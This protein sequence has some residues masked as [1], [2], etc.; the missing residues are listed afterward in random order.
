M[1]YQALLATASD[2]APATAGLIGVGEFGLTL[3]AQSRRIDGLALK[4][5]CDQ[6]PDRVRRAAVAL[7]WSENRVAFANDRRAA[8]AAFERGDLVVTDDW[9]VAVELPIDVVVEAT[10]SAE[11]GA[12]TASAAIDNGRHLVLVTKETDAVIGPLLSARARAAGLVLSQVD[13]D[14]PSLTMGLVSWA[15]ALGLEIVCAGKASTYDFVIDLEA[16]CVTSDGITISV[17]DAERLWA[18]PPASPRELVAARAAACEAMARRA[19]PDFCEIC[20]IANG[21][22]LQPDI[23]EL[24]AAIART[25]ELPDLFRPEASGGV[26]G[27][28]GRLDVFNCFRR[29]DEISFA[30]G[31]FAVVGLPD[32]KTGELFAE[33][34]I[35]V[36]D[37]HDHALIFNPTH[38][39]GVEAPMSI[40]SAVRL[41]RSTGSDLIRPVCDVVARAT[42]ELPAGTLLAEGKR[43]R[44]DGVEALLVDYTPGGPDRP[45]PLFMAT[46]RSLTRDVRAGE[47]LTHDAVETPADSLLWRLR[48]E[49]DEQTR[50]DAFSS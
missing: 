18:G 36:S 8:L 12:E 45:I 44:I 35:P 24:H 43:H 25:V 39:L 5:L 2:A 50:R 31:V 9:R 20:L 42:R 41:G 19:P 30:G 26:L 48:A 34:G 47:V 21:T 49:Q 40:L 37:D 10:G 6:E 33:K 11:T 14:Q 29:P 3:L 38:L 7:G 32:R 4:V 27:G 17:A 15:R 23:P 46:N 13:G 16:G 28:H 22:G 1:N